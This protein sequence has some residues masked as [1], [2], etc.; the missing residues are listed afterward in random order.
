MAHLSCCM[1][2]QLLQ[3][4]NA[5][6]CLLLCRTFACP[7]ASHSGRNRRR[8]HASSP[9][10]CLA[11]AE[12]MAL[13]ATFTSLAACSSRRFRLRRCFH[14]FTTPSTASRPLPCCL[15][16]RVPLRTHQCTLRHRTRAGSRPTAPP[17]RP[18]PDVV[19]TFPPLPPHRRP[20]QRPAAAAALNSQPEPL[21]IPPRMALSHRPHP[22]AYPPPPR[23]LV[24]SFEVSVVPQ[25]NR[26]PKLLLRRSPTC[27]TATCPR[28]P[29]VVRVCSGERMP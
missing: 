19:S 29:R 20:P 14:F 3:M 4:A 25:R 5:G 28:L 16:R 13:A 23:A 17:F 7:M 15:R 21:R 22:Q 26:L 12:V 1:R 18:P 8:H 24:T 6:R 27:P 10:P 11:V 2:R 9:H